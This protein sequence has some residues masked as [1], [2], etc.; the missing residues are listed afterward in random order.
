MSRHTKLGLGAALLVALAGAWLWL[1]G[2]SGGAKASRLEVSA[3]PPPEDSVSFAEPEASALAVPITIDL[4]PL[5]EE[6]EN[7]VPRSWGSL[8]ER[9]DVSDDGSRQVAVELEREPLEVSLHGTMARASTTIYYRVRGWYDPPVL[10]EV[11]ASCG[12][13]EDEPRP[14][15]HVE[16]RAPITLTSE[17]NL[18]TR[19]Q[20]DTIRAATDTDRDQCEITIFDIDMTGTVVG[21]A[22]EFLQGRTDD[23]DER[24]AEADIRSEFVDWWQILLTPIDLTEDTWLVLAPES[25]RRGDIQGEGDAVTVPLD[26]VARPR[27]VLGSRPPTLERALPPLDSGRVE[28]GLQIR[29]EGRA[30]YAGAAERL[31]E[32]LAGQEWTGMGQTVR[33]TGV[34]LQPT[35][36]GRLAVMATVEG[37]VEGSLYLV[38]TPQYD[39]GTGMIRV[40]DLAFAV[41]TSSALASG[42]AWLADSGIEEYLREQASVQADPAVEWAADKLR[43]GLNRELDDGVRLEGS[44]HDVRILGIAVGRDA[45]LIRAAADADASLI[46]EEGA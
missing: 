9:L 37:D 28:P 38:G 17:W 7:V 27:V 10:P 18:R 40:P 39:A 13:D 5:V 4:R 33:L 36:E 46:I 2:G 16:V 25:L 34:G 1:G 45:F 11:S 6:L 21:K 15:L 26:L 44:V 20:V 8:D 22:R 41:E 31:T 24:I 3:P 23:L 29:I 42:A 35:T 12:T 19:L 32:E 43:E 14:R 30:E